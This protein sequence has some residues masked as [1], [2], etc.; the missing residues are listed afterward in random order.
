MEITKE[1]NLKNKLL[2]YK[3]YASIPHLSFSRLGPSE[4][5]VD[6][7]QESYLLG[8]WPP[9]FSCNLIVEEKL[10]G[11][12]VC[13]VLKDNELLTLSRNGFD[14]AT[15]NQEQHLMFARYVKKNTAKFKALFGS[16][17]KPGE[18]RIV[19][20]WLAL[21]H[22]TKYTVDDPF[23]VLDAYSHTSQEDKQ[24]N[25]FRVN[26]AA[27]SLG[28]RRP[29]LFLNIKDQ[30]MLTGFPDIAL[31]KN[32][33][34][35]DGIEGCIFRLL[36]KKKKADLNY[37]PW[38]IAKAIFPHKVDGK[39]LMNKQIIWNWYDGDTVPE[40]N[41]VNDDTHSMR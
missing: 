22:G 14:C 23:V 7:K 37:E 40:Y 20:E 17:D 27:L 29:A 19:G 26:A 5:T 13:V 35:H 4:S 36:R 21:A 16:L 28:F 24:I 41:M 32:N 8:Q 34:A 15:S 1:K 6:A 11:S 38:L 31:S 25:W 18:L 2:S 3:T 12:N 10:D 30:Q 9:E 33:D 39:Y